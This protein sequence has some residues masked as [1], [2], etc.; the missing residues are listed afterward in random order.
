MGSEAVAQPGLFPSDRSGP[1]CSSSGTAS[2][3]RSSPGRRTAR[4]RRCPSSAGARLRLLARRLANGRSTDATASHLAR[5]VQTAEAIAT[6][7]GLPVVQ[8]PDLREVELGEWSNGGYRR[9]AAARDPEFLRFVAAGRWDLI[10]GSEGD[11][12]F[13]HRVMTTVHRLAER[14]LGQSLVVVCHGG[15][16]NAILA[17]IVGVE[18]STFSPIE[19]TSVTVVRFDEPTDHW[20]V[21]TVNDAVAPLRRRRR[22][23]AEAT[24]MSEPFVLG[25]DLDGVCGDYTAA[26]RTGRGDRS[27]HRPVDVRPQTS[28]DFA[29][30]GVD[31]AGF[32]RCIG[33]PCSSIGC[34]ARWIRCRAAP[35]SLWRLS[36][37]G[38]WIRIITHRLCVNWG[39]AVAVADTVAWLDHHGIPYR[40]L[41]FLGRKPE[42]EADA[43]S[44]T[45]PTTSGPARPRATR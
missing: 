21:V 16:I 9:R 19:N 20:L 13:R 30:W 14:H 45:V 37:A 23:H 43:T 38:V 3:R 32:D 17:E 7:R 1:S 29:E 5:A 15:V 22:D 33:W 12:P 41:C 6:V 36:D 26:F 44:M 35:K 27:R 31:P 40:D 18:R 24:A 8:D 2:P 42:V 28:W 4:T 11:G 34:S 39:H 10:P 25:V